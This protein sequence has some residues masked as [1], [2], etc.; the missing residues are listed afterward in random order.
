MVLNSNDVRYKMLS[1]ECTNFSNYIYSK[2]AIDNIAQHQA[3]VVVT[4]PVVMIMFAYEYVMR[5]TCE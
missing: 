2:E 3:D 1:I 5:C 4:W